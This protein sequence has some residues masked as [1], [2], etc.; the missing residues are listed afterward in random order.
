MPLAAAGLARLMAFISAVR[1]AV[2]CSAVK[3]FCR[4]G[5]G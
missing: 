4:S 3:D 5:S 1:L 2:S